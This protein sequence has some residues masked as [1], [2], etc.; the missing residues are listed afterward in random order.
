MKVYNNSQLVVN[1]VNETYQARWKKMVA[2]LDKAKELMGSISAVI[3]EV[4]PR[5]KNSNANAL[6]KLASTKDAELLNAVPLEFLSE[7][8][9]KQ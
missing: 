5:L 9:I 2:Y 8:S 1:Q 6:A 4:V 3:V 7:P